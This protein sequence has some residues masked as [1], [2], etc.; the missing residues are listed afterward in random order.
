MQKALR[1]MAKKRKRL[2]GGKNVYAFIRRK[3]NFAQCGCCGAKMVRKRLR[4][5]E[6]KSVPKTGRRPE[7]PYPEL[8]SRCMR[9]RIKRMVR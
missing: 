5:N 7:R 4:A 9:A 2:P 6:L 1:L 8:C 3:P